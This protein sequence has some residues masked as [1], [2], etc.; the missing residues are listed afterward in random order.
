M[1]SWVRE[2]ISEG[3]VRWQSIQQQRNST[4]PPPLP[5][6]HII[7]SPDSTP[8]GNPTGSIES[9]DNL[10]LI[11]PSATQIAIHRSNA[12]LHLQLQE[13]TL[14]HLSIKPNGS[15]VKRLSNISWKDQGY[16]FE[17]FFL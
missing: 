3:R 7:D 17:T 15:S 12:N 6:P 1:L 8:I 9:D 5:P 2:K 10:S 13:T 16:D 4:S 14:D 11:R